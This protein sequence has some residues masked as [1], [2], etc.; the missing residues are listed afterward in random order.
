MLYLRCLKIMKNLRNMFWGYS[1]DG[2]YFNNHTLLY[3]Q[4]GNI[5]S[6]QCSVFV[7][8]FDRN[9]LSNLITQFR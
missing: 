3:K 5:V 2:L 7:I 9:L 8:N 6:N 4:I 1:F